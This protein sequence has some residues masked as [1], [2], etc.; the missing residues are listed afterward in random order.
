MKTLTSRCNT[1]TKSL[2][3]FAFTVMLGFT[4]ASSA[5]TIGYYNLTNPADTDA[6]A[7]IT[8][9]GHTAVQLTGLTSPELSGIEVLWILNPSNGGY[10]SELLDNADA[11]ANFVA[12]GGTLMFHDRFVTDAAMIIPGAED[13]SFFRDFSDDASIELGPGAVGELLDGPGGIIDADSLD[14]GNSSSHGY[15]LASSLP[16]GSLV[17]LTRTDASEAVDFYYSLG[18][19]N[20][21]YS[22][23]PLDFYLG[24][25]NVN[26]NNYAANLA[27]FI[28]NLVG[29][30]A[31]PIQFQHLAM[32]DTARQRIDI[33]H[34]HLRSP[35]ES[36]L[37]VN[38]GYL[39]AERGDSEPG[40]ERAFRNW[41]R[42]LLVGYDKRIKENIQL[43]GAIS[44]DDAGNRSSF[45]SSL[46]GE[47]ESYSAM[48]FGR[49]NLPDIAE[50]S[51]WLEFIAGYSDLS[52]IELTRGELRGETDGSQTVADLKLGLDLNIQ[53]D[54][55]LTP[56]LGAEYIQTRIDSFSETGLGAIS[57]GST[58]AKSTYA[59]AGIEASFGTLEYDTWK[60]EPYVTLQYR[61][62]VSTSGTSVDTT[63]ASASTDSMPTS[64]YEFDSD[65]GKL[66]F[67]LGITKGNLDLNVAI[68]YTNGNDNLVGTTANLQLNYPL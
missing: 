49:F 57:F 3:S 42:S 39:D 6:E 28:F 36:G 66:G 15:A 4:S 16:A 44:Y 64:L 41:G 33:I 51:L 46:K 7:P 2:L 9:A 23:I 20:V 31:S 43:G 17:V 55:L 60:L 10:A 48:A 67:N 1:F 14:G 65:I 26:F 5:G 58:R 34:Q 62:L 68:T 21:Y 11:I 63:L 13:I 35:L 18:G 32:A 30:S 59:I 52:D 61:D 29:P 24:G 12:G 54:V 45:D 38:I 19:G 25:G 47:Y 8:L 50:Q 53:G 37:F 40:K 22:S 27:A 56:I